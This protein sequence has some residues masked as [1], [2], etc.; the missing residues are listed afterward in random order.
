MANP[1]SVY[2][3]EVRKIV[4]VPVGKDGLFVQP[5]ETGADRELVEGHN[6]LNF[7]N[8]FSFADPWTGNTRTYDPEGNYTCGMCN[9]AE[10]KECLLIPIIISR[11]AGSCR[12]WENLCAGDPEL[13]LS[14][15]DT[16]PTEVAAYGV[17]KNGQGFGCHRCPYSSAAFED[18]SQG[19]N[20]YC[21]KGDFRTV[22]NAC[23][24][25]NGAPTVGGEQLE[26][27]AARLRTLTR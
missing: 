2:Q 12:H 14:V 15:I 25:L 9:K 16:E 20:L 7:A 8:N 18:D 22:R 24:Q 23:C 19:R 6:R 17:A 5:R 21:G 1:D 11:E 3:P 4:T 10:G 26:R 13:H 27:L